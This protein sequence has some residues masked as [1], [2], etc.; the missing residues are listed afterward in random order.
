VDIQAL[1]EL[2]TKLDGTGQIV[3]LVW[4]VLKVINLEKR[5]AKVEGL[6][7]EH[8]FSLLE[9]IKTIRLLFDR[10]VNNKARN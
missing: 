1:V 7:Q 5:L 8:I 6:I 4:L 2:L 3:V 9:E 10:N